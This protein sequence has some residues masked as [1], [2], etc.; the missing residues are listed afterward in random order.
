ML[1][2]GIPTEPQALPA[3]L[4]A[5]LSDKAWGQRGTPEGPEGPQCCRS[6]LVSFQLCTSELE[7]GLS[8][9]TGIQG[10]RNLGKETPCTRLDFIHH[11][12]YFS[13]QEGVSAGKYPEQDPGHPRDLPS[14]PEHRNGPFR[15]FKV[16]QQRTGSGGE[17]CSGSLPAVPR[18]LF[19]AFPNLLTV[20]GQC[21]SEEGVTEGTQGGMLSPRVRHR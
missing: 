15:D 5:E 8:P 10:F 2:N 16:G 6:I 19:P 3:L 7:P 21:C 18:F 11:L 14:I 13:H 9:V 1:K 17:S 4:L 12:N 20:P